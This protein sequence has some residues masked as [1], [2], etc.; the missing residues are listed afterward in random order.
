V[1]VDDDL[2]KKMASIDINWSQYIRQAI[3]ERIEREERKS[4]AAKILESLEAKKLKVPK[5]F[6]E[7]TIREMRKNR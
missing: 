2:R 7:K 4:A 3:L 1:K 5:G 6:I